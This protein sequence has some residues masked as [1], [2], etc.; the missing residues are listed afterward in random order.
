MV[1]IMQFDAVAHK[2]GDLK[3]KPFKWGKILETSFEGIL[4]KISDQLV[5]NQVIKVHARKFFNFPIGIRIII[6]HF[7]WI[8]E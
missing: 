5:Q 2:M 1:Q 6:L 8:L 4:L 7:N 3:E